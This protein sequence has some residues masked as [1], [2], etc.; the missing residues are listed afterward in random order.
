MAE[1]EELVQALSA[2]LMKTAIA[3]QRQIPIRNPLLDQ[4]KSDYIQAYQM[5]VLVA[6][7]WKK[8]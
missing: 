1:D 8:S 6:D 4:I 7:E 2:H 5:A 3:L